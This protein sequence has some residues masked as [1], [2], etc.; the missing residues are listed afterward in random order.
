M[1]KKLIPDCKNQGRFV[2]VKVNIFLF[3]LF[4]LYV[5]SRRTFEGVDLIDIGNFANKKRSFLLDVF[6]STFSAET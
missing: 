4:F 1:T 3:Y 6:R 2:C 5:N